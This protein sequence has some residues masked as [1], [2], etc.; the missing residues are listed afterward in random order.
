[1]PECERKTRHDYEHRS[2]CKG[3]LKVHLI[4][5]TRFR[6]PCL[7]GDLARNCKEILT[8]I[9]EH[10]GWIIQKI[11]TDKRGIEL[12]LLYSDEKFAVPDNVYII[13]MVNTADR[14]L[15]MLDYAL[16]RRFSFIDLKPGFETEGFLS[17][18]AG[19]AS[20]KFNRLVACIESLNAVIAADESLGEGF[21]IGHSYFC[22]LT[23]DTVTDQSLYAIVKF[24]I[25][26]L[27]KEYWFD[28][29]SKVRDWSN[30]LRSVIK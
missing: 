23:S 18:R 10:H 21:C 2:H 30:N 12:Q 3:V 1:M 9:A 11:E 17:Y 28:E 16:R 24:E 7:T 4:F 22:N 13:G 27:L 8:D 15:A 14:S 29:P 6:K 20:E 5:V 25:I 26:P 19:L